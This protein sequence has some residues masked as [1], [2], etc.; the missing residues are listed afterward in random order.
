[1]IRILFSFDRPTFTQMR[2]WLFSIVIFSFLVA[3]GS[4]SSTSSSESTEKVTLS[5]ASATIPVGQNQHL[6]VTVVDASGKA[7]TPAQVTYSVSN[8][9]IADVTAQGDLIA[10]QPGTTMVT[11][12]VGGVLSNPVEITVTLSTLASIDLSPPVVTLAP[13][14]TV[15]LVAT[16]K[17]SN[18]NQ[19]LN[20]V[21]T[22]NSS[23]P[24]VA[25]VDNAGRVT[26]IKTGRAQI[27]ASVPKSGNPAE[28]VTS[29]A[30]EVTVQEGIPPVAKLTASP[31]AG[32]IP[33]TVQFDASGSF[34]PNGTIASYDW[35]FGDQTA[36][37]TGL[38]VSHTYTAT[39]SFIVTLIVT[40]N[41]GAQSTATTAITATARAREGGTLLGKVG[42]GWKL[43]AHVPSDLK[44]VHFVDANTGWV[45]GLNMGIFKTTDGGDHWVKQDNIIWKGDPPGYPPIPFDVFFI[46]QNRGWVAGLPELI[47]YTEDGGKSWVEQNRNPIS[48]KDGK[49]YSK[50][51]YCQDFDPGGD[52]NHFYGAYLRRIRFAADGQTGYAAGRFRYIYKTTDG[53][54]NWRLL[55]SNWK[56]PNWNP[57]P[58]CENADNPG[59]PPIQLHFTAYSPHLFGL[60]VLSPNELFIVG[61]AAGTYNCP[62][63]FNTIA[64]SADGGVTWDFQVDLDR[65]Q[66]LF[67]IHFIGDTGWAV[68][69]T[70]TI[71]KTVDHGKSWQVVNPHRSITGV[72]LLGLA[73][74][75]ADQVW[76][77]GADGFIGRTTDGGITWE[78]QRSKTDLRLER[79]SFIDS[80]RGWAASHL[81]SVPKTE[82]GGE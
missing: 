44:G 43:S 26:G 37:S 38:S 53:G 51:N 64:H 62:E 57:D 27:T 52:C 32:L 35:N 47:L 63:W 1:M 11:A 66:R 48:P 29:P 5:P 68:G 22:W 39:G 74:P 60:D 34:A 82:S 58:V 76:V 12:S 61:G 18:G 15:Q 80:L 77:V 71:L 36:I 54:K 70:G 33:L 23:D 56:S 78:R 31:S 6:E 79:V 10:K 24:T 8:P 3:C 19:L 49:P 7:V 41:Q 55:P 69:G 17:E 13:R 81:G 65:K 14:Q 9:E 73:F 25:S 20:V 50:D 67:D 72:D 16:A 2:S 45:V 75:A 42:E 4:S 40:D 46:D 30:V 59:G 21:F 28:S